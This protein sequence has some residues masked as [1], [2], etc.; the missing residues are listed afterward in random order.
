MP[1]AWSQSSSGKCRRRSRHPGTH[2]NTGWHLSAP[3]QRRAERPDQPREF[4]A[5]QG[6]D[7]ETEYVKYD[8]VTLL[9]TETDIFHFHPAEKRFKRGLSPI[10]PCPLF[11]LFHSLFHCGAGCRRSVLWSGGLGVTLAKQCQPISEDHSQQATA[12]PKANEFLYREQLAV[13]FP[14]SPEELAKNISI[15]H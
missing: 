14:S 10:S 5:D 1:A 6:T 13:F 9:K 7:K 12:L 11:P 8:F 15:C 4:K 3:R 2:S